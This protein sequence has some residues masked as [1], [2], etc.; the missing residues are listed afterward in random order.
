M[1]DKM[2]MYGHKREGKGHQYERI[3]CWL[4]PLLV[5][6]G[7]A[8]DNRISLTEFVEMQKQQSEPPATTQPSD[9][10]LQQRQQEI[11]ELLDEKLCPYRVGQGDILIISLESLTEEAGLPPI[12]ARVDRN[13]SIELPIVG[14]LKVADQELEDVENTIRSAFVPKVYRDLAVHVALSEKELTEVV[15]TGATMV[16]GV[17]ELRRTR[18]NLLF[19]I[20]QAGGMTE[21]ASGSVTLK[22][23][24]IP[25]DSITLNLR[26]PKD[27]RTALTLPPLQNGDMVQVAAATPNMIF[28][29]GL[30]MFPQ[31]EEYPAGVNITILQA[32]AAAGG[33]RADITPRE[34]TLIRRMEDGQDVHVK[35]DMDRL[36]AGQDPNITLAAG[37][38]LWVPHTIET[39]VQDWINKNV[40]FRM[41]ATVTAGANYNASY[42]AMGYKFL[43][44]AAEQTM[45]RGTSGSSQTLQDR[46]DPFGFLM[47]PTT[48]LTPVTAGQ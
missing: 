5:M 8:A 20:V 13:G 3:L 17:V 47:Q 29:G 30:V 33:L 6:G 10:V 44:D 48:A 23:I 37:D 45:G 7:C 27:L 1:T 12:V 19:A 25:D 15:V 26:D 21:A 11:T 9:Q 18:R 28:V 31:V 34:G 16:P 39:R 43:N 4:I 38:V 46:F 40:F 22:R 42:N 32:I 36:A 24:R 35:L 14:L 2:G 41:G